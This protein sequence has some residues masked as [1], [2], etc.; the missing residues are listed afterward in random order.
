[1]DSGGIGL[2]SGRAQ[3]SSERPEPSAAPA[4]RWR[5]AD[6]SSARMV[7][8]PP[9]SGSPSTRTTAR[10]LCRAL[11]ARP[12][13]RVDAPA[14]PQPP[15]TATQGAEVERGGLGDMVTGPL[16]GGAGCT[17]H[18][19]HHHWSP[20]A[21]HASPPAE[22]VEKPALSLWTTSGCAGMKA[23]LSPP[24]GKIFPSSMAEAEGRK[25]RPPR[26][27]DCSGGTRGAQRAAGSSRGKGRPPP[28]GRAGVVT[29]ARLGGEEPDQGCTV[30]N[31]P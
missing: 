16:L 24:A 23:P 5:P 10:P 25:E 11:R 6:R 7:S 17:A 19:H 22:S 30:A 13:A 12:A 9:P 20:A 27:G 8:R 31:D 14:P 1:M 21:R 15:N 2:P 26:R 3:V 18:P 4:E 28:G 29:L